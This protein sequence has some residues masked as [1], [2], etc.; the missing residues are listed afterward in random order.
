VKHR[1]LVW[2]LPLVFLGALAGCG[3]EEPLRVYEAVATPRPQPLEMPSSWRRATPDQFS[4]YAFEAGEGRDRVAITISSAGG[5]LLANINRWRRQVGLENLD[6]RGLP[7]QLQPVKIDQYEGHYVEMESPLEDTADAAG[8]P[9]DEKEPADG[10]PKAAKKKPRV[11]EAI[12]GAIIPA[13]GRNWFFK[14]RG[15]IAA[16]ASE[17]ANFKTFV[18]T[19]LRAL[20]LAVREPTSEESADGN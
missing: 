3:R 1:R 8:H 19:G 16:A 9:G 20:T 12:Y 15:P 13:K 5:D 7:R 18:E 10:S 4:I 6:E 11:R 14:L 17:R 2:L